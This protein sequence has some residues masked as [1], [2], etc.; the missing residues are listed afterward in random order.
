MWALLIGLL[1]ATALS[2]SNEEEWSPVH[3]YHYTHW[4]RTYTT[5]V[6][7]GVYYEAQCPDSQDFII[8]QLLPAYE[9]APNLI[10][11]IFIP[12]G[13]AHTIRTPTGYE[14]VCQHGPS[15]CEGNKIHA[16]AIDV[17]QEIDIQLKYIGCL[18]SDYDYPELVG[19]KCAKQLGIDWNPILW[20]SRGT[21]GT[22]LLRAYG[23]ATKA[24]DPPVSFIPTVTLNGKQGDQSAILYDL[25]GEICKMFESPK[26][27]QC[28]PWYYRIFE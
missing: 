4:R 27:S 5:P 8:D 6:E 9:K 1:L 13:K 22:E 25:W 24:L 2:A 21:R 15:E 18:M 3:K 28:V 19:Q 23:E 12:Y 7:V 17:L 20:C 26:P 16:C 11:P 14:F 10:E